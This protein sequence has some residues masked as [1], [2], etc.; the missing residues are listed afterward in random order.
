MTN[1]LARTQK[2]AVVAL[3]EAL[4]KNLSWGTDENHTHTQTENVSQDSRSSGRGLNPGP[5]NTKQNCYPLEC[6]VQFHFVYV[7]LFIVYSLVNERVSSSGYIASNG[8]RINDCLV[9]RPLS[10]TA[11]E[12]Y[13]P[14]YNAA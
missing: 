8:R 3:F 9:R 13:L 2:E 11:E 5:L 14:G 6:D 12:I 4:A 10:F 1:G 7:Y